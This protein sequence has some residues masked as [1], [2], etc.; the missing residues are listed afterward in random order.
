MKLAIR[1]AGAITAVA[2]FLT[3]CA[4]SLQGDLYQTLYASQATLTASETV[5]KQYVEGSFGKPD[6]AVV[7]DLKTYDAK[8]YAAL[9]PLVL[10]AQA[11]ESVST[12]AVTTAQS[13]VTD[14]YSYLASHNVGGVK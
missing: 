11:G 10:D 2:L 4:G 12:M 3:A 14:F 6:S 9:H 8:A 7:S 1:S 13:Y 5:A